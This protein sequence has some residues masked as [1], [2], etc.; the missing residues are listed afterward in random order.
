VRIVPSSLRSRLLALILVAVLPPILLMAFTAL[1]QRRRAERDAGDEALR[2]ARLIAAHEQQRLEGARLLLEG[3]VGLPEVRAR[4]AAACRV[5]FANIA[6]SHEALVVIAAADTSGR[7]FAASGTQTPAQVH[8]APWFRRALEGDGLA[9]GG[10][11]RA[12]PPRPMDLV[13][14]LPVRDARGRAIGVVFTAI[15]LDWLRD[16]GRDLSLPSSAS[17]LLNDSRGLVLAR[18]PDPGKW[19]GRHL[20]SERVLEMRRRGSGW[21]RFTSL[22]GSDRIGGFAPLGDPA[23]E[24]LYVGVGL[25]RGEVLGR[26]QRLF[27]EG[28]VFLLMLG[29]VTLWV[30]WRGARRVVL[31]RVDALVAATRRVTTGDLA[32]RTNLPYGRGELSELSRAFDAMTETLERRRD[33]NDQLHRT[34]MALSLA[35]ELTGLYNRRGFLMLARQQIDVADRS[36]TPISL[37]FA[38][39][40]QL[41]WI[42]DTFGHAE[43]DAALRDAARILKQTFRRSDVIARL[44]GDEFVVLAVESSPDTGERLTARLSRRLAAERSAWGRRYTLSLSLGRVRYAPHRHP[45]IE[46]LLAEGDALMYTQKRGA[47][48]A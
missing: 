33:E 44:G 10:A 4:D 24:P 26:A 30:A 16:V 32:A 2:L 22:D 35:D 19:I 25:A 18:Y 43:G 36:G 38:D 40:D 29:G 13:A 34:L 39:V 23:D 31:R 1:E 9:A 37:I 48:Q 28:L 6:A 42:N 20:P 27:L 21:M 17:V 46:A 12:G 47:H 11:A 14:A 45:S 8:D 7:V 5:R 41:K 3:L 15:G